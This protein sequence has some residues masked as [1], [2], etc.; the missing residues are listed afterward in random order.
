M[1]MHAIG[2][3]PL[4]IF[5]K[6][7]RKMNELKSHLLWFEF[8][9]ESLL[10]VFSTVFSSFSL[11]LNCFW[12]HDLKRF[13][14]KSINCG[15]NFPYFMVSVALDKRNLL[16]FE[17]TRKASIFIPLNGIL[18]QKKISKRKMTKNRFYYRLLSAHQSYF[19]HSFEFSACSCFYFGK[20]LL[21]IPIQII[22][23]FLLAFF[24]SWL[25]E[26]RFKLSIN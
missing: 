11:D 8:R 18:S 9:F 10:W 15:W 21:W 22:P 5:S 4:V 13:F 19:N 2:E 20:L 17:H 24:H 25:S 26:N 12:L 7:P 14:W 16:K 1:K 6:F 23:S 3:S